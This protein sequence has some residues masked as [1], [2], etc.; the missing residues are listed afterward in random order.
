MKAQA[1][2]YSSSD[3]LASALKPSVKQMGGRAGRPAFSLTQLYRCM[4]V[5]LGLGIFAA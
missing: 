5:N 1:R 2:G 4:M 3:A